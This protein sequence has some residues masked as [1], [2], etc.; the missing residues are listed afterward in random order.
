M[1][2]ADSWYRYRWLFL[3]CPSRK[4]LSRLSQTT[5]AAQFFV[6]AMGVFPEVQRK[7]QAELDNVIGPSRLPDMDDYDS[8]PYIRSVA[9]ESMRWMPVVPF[10]LSHMV[11]ADDEYKG[12]RIPKGSVII[13]VST[14]SFPDTGSLSKVNGPV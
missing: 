2:D 13:P 12:H 11:I 7:A 14:P 6:A 10:G 5:S 4:Y 1:D 8:L 9:L 3:C